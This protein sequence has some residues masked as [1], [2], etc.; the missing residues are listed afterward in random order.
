MPLI[1][2]LAGVSREELGR[3]TGR[4][5]PA[6]QL[7]QRR[8]R[9]GADLG[10]A[11]GRQGWGRQIHHGRLRV[12]RR[13]RPG[14]LDASLRVGGFEHRHQRSQGVGLQLGQ[15]RTHVVVLGLPRR[16]NEHLDHR[17]HR[18]PAGLAK[19]DQGLKTHGQRG[20]LQLLHQR[21]QPLRVLLLAL[22]RIEHG[23]GQLAS[24]GNQLGPGGDLREHLG[25]E[26]PF[27]AASGRRRRAWR[28]AL[29]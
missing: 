20:V 23:R 16:V 28:R 14:R 3:R 17:P 24:F 7:T 2:I 4:R 12:E 26:L 19:L 13:Q 25:A 5:E 11:V 9:D 27:E 8:R 10:R 21:G 1:E 15:R 18:R 6:G 22:H 29:P